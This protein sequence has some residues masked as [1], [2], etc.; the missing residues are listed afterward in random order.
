MDF[1]FYFLRYLMISPDYRKQEE[2]EEICKNCDNKIGGKKFE[3][4]NCLF[5]SPN[6]GNK[7]FNLT[8]ND[9]DYWTEEEEEEEEEEENPFKGCDECGD[10]GN[11]YGISFYQKGNKVVCAGCMEIK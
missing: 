10:W 1:I 5:C 11:G 3:I 4:R 7:Y 2:E 6:C 8:Y 9:V